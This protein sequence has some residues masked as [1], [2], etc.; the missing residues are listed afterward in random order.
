V[1]NGHDVPAEVQGAIRARR[2]QL[3][4]SCPEVLLIGREL[5]E[6]LFE[7]DRILRMGIRRGYAPQWYS[8]AQS[9]RFCPLCVEQR[10]YH[11][12]LWAMPLVMACPL[13]GCSLVGRCS[14]C[15]GLLKWT[16]LG[17]GFRCSCGTAVA[18]MRSLPAHHASVQLSRLI[19]SS[20]ELCEVALPPP[21]PQFATYRFAHVYE[22]LDLA[23]RARLALKSCGSSCTR[24]PEWYVSP[25]ARPK[26]PHVWEVAF[27]RG[28]PG[29]VRRKAGNL[30]RWAF[31]A[32]RGTLVH[33]DHNS[34][35]RASDMFWSA[36]DRSDN[37]LAKIVLEARDQAVGRFAAGIPALDRVYFHPR[38]TVAQ[39]VARVQQLE[40]L[41]R[42]LRPRFRSLP[43][44]CR[45]PSH[46]HHEYG[47]RRSLAVAI[48]NAMFDAAAKQVALEAFDPLTVRWHLPAPE[49]AEIATLPALADYLTSLHSAELAFVATLMEH[50][51]GLDQRHGRART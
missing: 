33:D 48:L 1:A 51:V 23:S 8:P 29:S 19:A 7:T 14:A 2:R 47:D 5:A 6:G 20:R 31:R 26:A 49:D 37:P 36:L 39:R 30:L 28:L 18:S 15:G 22:L 45:L 25:N 21:A 3:D 46:G 13:H 4:D 12:T 27:V 16:K 11:L 43:A 10:G 40:E 38:L 41:W 17:S 35:I 44:G 50:C 32:Q 34:A 9:P 42:G 24:Q